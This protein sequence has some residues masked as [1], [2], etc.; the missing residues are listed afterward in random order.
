[1]IALASILSQ[2]ICYEQK[3]QCGAETDT[4]CQKKSVV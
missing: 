1:M 3:I 2:V 4:S